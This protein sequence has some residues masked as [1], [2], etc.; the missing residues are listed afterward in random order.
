MK[1]S[2]SNYEVHNSNLNEELIELKL[3]AFRSQMNPHF[4][5]NALNAIQH[6]ITLEDKRSALIYLSVF[7]K[8][9]RFYLKY[10]AKESVPLKDE[11]EMLK[12]YF[13]LQ[14]LRYSDQFNYEIYLEGNHS[15][16]NANIPS[17]ILQTLFE[18]IIEHAIYNQ[19]KDYQVNVRFEV[20]KINVRIDIGF[21]YKADIKAKAKYTPDY[22]LN[23]MKWQDQIRLLNSLR[24][25]KIEKNVTF[26]R[27]SNING[28]NIVLILPN[29]Q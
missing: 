16:I 28:G 17:F 3:H 15:K 25:Y 20:T 18:N 4:I 8:L 24:N 9:I 22:R 29:L 1:V 11:I 19:Y 12:D 2:P 7:G 26:H 21:E 5:F 14:R 27:K 10:M 13:K 6:F 23:L